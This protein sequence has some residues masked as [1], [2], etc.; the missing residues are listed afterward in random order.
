MTQRTPVESPSENRLHEESEL[1][2]AL[3]EL[4]ATLVDAFGAEFSILDGDSGNLLHT[5][6]AHGGLDWLVRAELCR[7]VARRQEPELVE[8]DEPLVSLAIPTTLGDREVVALGTFLSRPVDREESRAALARW[9]GMSETS[10]AA[11]LA[12][13]E[14]WPPVRL[15]RV[16]RLLVD[17]LDSDRGTASLEKELSSLSL[18]LATTYEEIS[19]LYHLTQNLK[20]S[21]RA[22]ELG[23]LALEWLADV[24]PV[25][26][27]AL[28]LVT[29]S[30]SD[31]GTHGTTGEPTLL[32]HGPAPVDCD[33]FLRLVAHLAIKLDHGPTIINQP[34]TA[35][36]SWP[37]PGIRQAIILPLSEG[38]NLFG[39]LAVFNH[40]EGNELGTVEGSLLTSV[41]A[42]LGIH[43]GNI[44]LYRQQA[45][46][47]NDVV[48]ALTS[49]IDA[50][51]PYTCGH[52]DRVGQVA[53]RL[54]EELGADSHMLAR[55]YL[56]GLLHDTGKIGIDDTVLRKRVA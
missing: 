33:G 28:Q 29:V 7:S 4:S 11:W 2:S 23:Q 36:A 44:E 48:R 12:D 43:S 35:D 1:A 17:K 22:E 3:V 38:N 56:G 47:V 8:D 51:D 14:I 39:Y 40:R 19:L 30:R 53:R 6:A 32:A 15:L 50:K 16:A 13:Q 26:S 49:A 41:A 27:L 46:F 10:L 20:L 34:L 37:F 52:S 55:I 5:A 24:L 25:E 45:E 54:A 21:S 31:D 9:L 18:N 42:I